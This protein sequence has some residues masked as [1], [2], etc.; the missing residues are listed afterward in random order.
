MLKCMFVLES[1]AVDSDTA[2]GVGLHPAT[3]ET[4][5]KGTLYLG[6][7]DQLSHYLPWKR[8]FN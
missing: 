8:S 1:H 6:H 5:S 7:S 2:G 4:S 3:E